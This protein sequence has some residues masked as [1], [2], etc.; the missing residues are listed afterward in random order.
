MLSQGEQRGAAVNCNMYQ[1]FTAR[2]YMLCR[3][4]VRLSVRLSAVRP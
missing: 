3:L 2:C 1:I 4:S